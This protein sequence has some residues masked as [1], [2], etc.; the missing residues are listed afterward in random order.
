[1]FIS[2]HEKYKEQVSFQTVVVDNCVPVL[3]NDDKTVIKDWLL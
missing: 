2:Y 1:M 3:T